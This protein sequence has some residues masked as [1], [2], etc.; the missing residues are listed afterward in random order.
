M[1]LSEARAIVKT[2]AEGVDPVTGE[3]FEAD[4]PYNRSRVIRALFT[5]HRYAH[6]PGSKMSPDERRQRNLELGR[7]KNAGLR[8]TEEDRSTVASG[9]GDGRTIEG[10]ARELDRSRAAIHAELIRQ[11]LVSPTPV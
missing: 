10:L 6:V 3:V 11:G 9:F 2:L 1:E 4:S 7:P 5:V 8:W